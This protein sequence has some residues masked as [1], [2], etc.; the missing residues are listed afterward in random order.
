VKKT[1]WGGP[2]L[3]Y[4]KKTWEESRNFKCGEGGSRKGGGFEH[5]FD[6]VGKK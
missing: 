3:A 2:L 6:L 4:E 5:K 1:N